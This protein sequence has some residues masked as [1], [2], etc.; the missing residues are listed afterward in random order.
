MSKIR[1]EIRSVRIGLSGNRLRESA[2]AGRRTG[3]GHWSVGEAEAY[4]WLSPSAI[5]FFLLARLSLAADKSP[6]LLF[7]TSNPNNN[8]SEQL[9]DNRARQGSV[10]G[11]W[12]SGP[13]G[14]STR[15]MRGRHYVC[16]A[17]RWPMRRSRVSQ[18][19][20]VVGGCGQCVS[21]C[22]LACQRWASVSAVGVQRVVGCLTSQHRLT[23]IAN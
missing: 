22:G 7:I 19:S 23:A 14:H 18:W 2:T 5:L 4:L 3:S 10:G 12:R 15:H 16:G 11:Q 8:R 1:R 13:S 21:V 20:V 9:Q 17:Q 6:F